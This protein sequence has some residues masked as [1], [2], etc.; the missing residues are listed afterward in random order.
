MRVNM[1]KSRKHTFITS[2]PYFIAGEG[3][4]GP[5]GVSPSFTMPCWSSLPTA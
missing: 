3:Y 4:S 2:L 5:M 1:A